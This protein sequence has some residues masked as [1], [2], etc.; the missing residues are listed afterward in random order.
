MLEDDRTAVIQ[1]RRSRRLDR[2]GL[3][4][5]PLLVLLAL[6]FAY[7]LAEIFKR[8]FTDFL[9]PQ[10]S[11]L[12]N[13]TWFFETDVNLTV[14]R[15][16]FFTALLVTALCLVLGYPY[17][18]LMTTVRRG[19]RLVLLGAV[20]LPFWTSLMVR[21]Y[22]W[23]ILLQDSGVVNTI[24]DKLGFP[25]FELIGNQR[26]VTIGMTQI[27][28]P[29]MVLPLYATLRG[30]DRTLLRAAQGLGA[31]PT[32]AFIRIFIPLSLPGVLAGCL[33]VLVLSLGFYVTP[34]LL[35]SPENA[36]LSQ[37]VV[38]QVNL[39]LAWGRAGVMALVLLLLT[40]ILLLGAAKLASHSRAY[41]QDTRA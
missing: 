23:I 19:W 16:T 36:L 37:L 35:G 13:Y 38:T 27:L 21:N 17:A 6:V 4:V 12:D 1:R 9:P 26:G 25:R 18:Y 28:L 32:V 33:L 14:L 10:T 11:G 5:L 39:L 41:Q 34:A 2:W 30:I 8:T 22:A 31:H 15:R 20:L 29:F 24:L 7:P 40:L 3:L